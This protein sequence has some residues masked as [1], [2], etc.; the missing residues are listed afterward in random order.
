MSS[1][2]KKVCPT[3]GQS[4]NE[5]QIPFYRGMVEAL[6]SV[7]EWCEIGGRHEFAKKEI[8]PLIGDVE[9]SVFAYWRWFGGMVYNPDGIKGHYGLNMDRCRQ[10][11]SGKLEIP[12]E[13]W[14]N[15]LTHELRYE[16][17]QTIDNI[18]MLKNFL[19]EKQNFISQ[20]RE[21]TQM[22]LI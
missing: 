8:K 19:D 21:P 9:S 12:T 4:V 17:Y 18:P 20:Y 6:K 5:R 14:T 1:V 11:F 7:F 10:F 2:N 15:P 13:I 22:G 16:N 3:C